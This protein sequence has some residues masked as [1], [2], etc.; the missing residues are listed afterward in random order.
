MIAC[1]G[2]PRYPNIPGAQEYGITSDDIFSLE[3]PPGK[4]LVVGAGYIGLECAG[5]LH[6]LGY[7]ATVLVRSVVLRGFDQQMAGIVTESMQQ[8]GVKFLFK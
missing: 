3:D 1:G 4:T 5:F 6:G 2:R 8:K 7:D